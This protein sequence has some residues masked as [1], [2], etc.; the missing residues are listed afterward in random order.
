M[1][2]RVSQTEG[3]QEDIPP[4][5][6]ILPEFLSHI[7]IGRARESASSEDKIPSAADPRR[8]LLFPSGNTGWCIWSTTSTDYLRVGPLDIGA[9]RLMFHRLP[10]CK[11]FDMSRL[12]SMAMACRADAGGCD[13]IPSLVAFG[14]AGKV[15]KNGEQIINAGR[16]WW[17]HVG[18][19]GNLT[20]GVCL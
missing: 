8:Q 12:V 9:T 19:P 6:G 1:V 3:V 20:S 7:W 16:N 15:G 18:R 11:R 13:D 14:A 17:D 10:S 5:I 2:P 4:R